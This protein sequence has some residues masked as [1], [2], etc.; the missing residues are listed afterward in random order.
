MITA[1]DLKSQL[2]NILIDRPS[3]N[4]DMLFIQVPVFKNLHEYFEPGE[5]IMAYCIV[6][7]NKQPVKCSAGRWLAVCSNKRLLFLS[8][9][10]LTQTELFY[11]PLKEIDSIVPKTSWLFGGC[12]ISSKETKVEIFHAGKADFKY[13]FPAL[14][15]AHSLA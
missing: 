1:E 10:L 9:G 5:T 14:Q 2:K 13:F 8:G 3:V 7:L 4:L 12:M 6:N 11:L 15:S